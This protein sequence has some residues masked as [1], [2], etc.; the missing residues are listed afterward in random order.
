MSKNKLLPFRNASLLEAGCDE[1]G[2]GCLAGPVFAAA[3]ILPEGF[4]HPELNDSKQLSL[5]KRE[6][7]RPVIEES[8]IAWAVAIAEPLE[9]DE[10]NILNA[11]FLAMHR[12]ISGLKTVPEFLLID[13]PRFNPYPGIPHGC[14][15]RGDGRFMSIAAASVLAKTHRDEY[16][17]RIHQEYPVY[18]WDRNKGYP[19]AQHRDAIRADGTCLYHRKSFRLLDGQLSL[20]ETLRLKE[21]YKI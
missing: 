7:L 17:L 9:I 10:I 3:V 2:R 21:N 18:H 16:M 15:I 19:T 13:G 11:S 1:A 6:L 5:R 14:E 8:A 4:Y 20:F 12:A